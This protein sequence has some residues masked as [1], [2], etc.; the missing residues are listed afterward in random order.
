[1]TAFSARFRVYIDGALVDDQ[2]VCDGFQEWEIDSLGAHHAI[3]CAAASAAGQLWF[4]EVRFG[5]G[6]QLRFGTDAGPMVMPQPIGLERLAEAL[7]ARW[8]GPE[9]SRPL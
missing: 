6:E 7:A 5:D 9:D 4:V 1:V 2:T 8:L 3:L